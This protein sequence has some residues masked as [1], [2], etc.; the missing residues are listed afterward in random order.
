MGEEGRREGGRDPIVSITTKMEKGKLSW[1]CVDL[2][3]SE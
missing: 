1:T 3:I 2:C